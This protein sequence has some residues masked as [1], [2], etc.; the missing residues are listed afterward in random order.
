[1]GFH[2]GAVNVMMFADDCVLYRS[3][4]CSDTNYSRNFSEKPR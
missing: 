4:V 2:K 1:M 3:N